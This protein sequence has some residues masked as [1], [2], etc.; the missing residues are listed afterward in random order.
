MFVHRAIKSTLVPGVAGKLV[1]ADSQP[2]IVRLARFLE[3]LTPPA[4]PNLSATMM[5]ER[6]T[7]FRLVCLAMHPA[8]TA[9]RAL[10]LAIVCF[11]PAQR[12]RRTTLDWQVHPIT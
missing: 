5:R 1:L 8:L 7:I 12:C 6:L 9:A 11:K 2:M 4:F 10:L 3:Y